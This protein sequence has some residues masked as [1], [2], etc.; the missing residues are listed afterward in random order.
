[1]ELTNPQ[2]KLSPLQFVMFLMNCTNL[3][4]K[5]KR[6]RRIA[7]LNGMCVEFEV[8]NI[9][10]IR[11]TKHQLSFSGSASDAFSG[12]GVCHFTEKRFDLSEWHLSVYLSTV[13]P[14]FSAT[15][16]SLSW[17]YTEVSVNRRA[18]Q[19]GVFVCRLS[20]ALIEGGAISGFAHWKFLCSY[21][22]IFVM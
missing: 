12:N 7:F 19:L 15:L 17:L 9:I 6:N 2:G 22:V 3:N 4:R 21:L 16:C 11:N 18:V 13:K 8:Y 20:W 14:R 10:L 5:N 1:M